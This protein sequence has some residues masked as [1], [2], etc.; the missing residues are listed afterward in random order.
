MRERLDFMPASA[1]LHRTNA[2]AWPRSVVDALPFA[3][4]VLDPDGVIVESNRALLE[5]CGPVVPGATCCD[6]LG[7]GTSTGGCCHRGAGAGTEALVALPSGASA[8]LTARRTERGGTLVCLRADDCTPTRPEPS[9][10]RRLLLTSLGRMRV[11]DT[12]AGQLCGPWLEQRPG[13]LLRFLVARRGR[14]VSA[15]E[16]ADA[17]WSDGEPRTATTV[18]YLVHTL[19]ERL[20]PG[21]ERRG[22]SSFIDSHRGGYRLNPDHVVVDADLFEREIRDGLAAQG[23][24]LG[25][26]LLERAVVRHRGEFLAEEPYADW[27]MGERERLRGLLA[28][29]LRTLADTAQA[30]GD[31]DLAQDRL[32]QLAELEPLDTG[33]QRDLISLCLLRG[34]RGEAVRRYEALQRRVQDAYGGS[35]GFALLPGPGGEL[36]VA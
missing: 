13:Q 25:A 9:A 21:R 28:R 4:A 7:C 11:E 22:R 17:L 10:P 8:W 23:G 6:A 31:L 12:A 2:T 26:R 27:A 5:L 36:A 20:E 32:A 1:P 35:P 19:R 30:A 3:V 24:E 18:R 16:I 29:A 14:V 15:D 34:R 33:V